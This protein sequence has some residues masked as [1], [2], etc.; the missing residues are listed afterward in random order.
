MPK[1]RKPNKITATPLNPTSISESAIHISTASKAALTPVSSPAH[2]LLAG[3]EHGGDDHEPRRDGTLTHAHY[4]TTC[5]EASEGVAG[6]LTAKGD[7]PD[8]NVNA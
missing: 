6:G 4:K 7:G 1:A 2:L 3:I 5:E 8:E